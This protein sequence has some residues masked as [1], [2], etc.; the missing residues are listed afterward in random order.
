MASSAKRGQLVQV[1]ITHERKVL[2][3]RWKTG[4]FTGRL[5]GLLGSWKSRENGCGWQGSA[6][7]HALELCGLQLDSR[8]LQPRALFSFIEKDGEDMIHDCDEIELIYEAETHELA[9]ISSHESERIS[10]SWHPWDRLPFRRMPAD[11]EYWYPRVLGL[12]EYLRGSFTFD[13]PALLDHEL[14][15]VGEEELGSAIMEME[16]SENQNTR[17]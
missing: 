15:Q 6:V 5:T 16:V 11:D 7:Q 12:G 9:K 14:T 4:D 17:T 1:L 10:L 13:G 2:L 8:R 3:G